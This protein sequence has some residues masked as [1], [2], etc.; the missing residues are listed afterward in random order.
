[1][2][3]RCFNGGQSV[4]FFQSVF[5]FF[6]SLFLCF[7]VS[8]RLLLNHLKYCESNV[9]LGPQSLLITKALFPFRLLSFSFSFFSFLFFYFSFLT[10]YLI[11]VFC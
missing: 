2:R 6:L 11:K 8:E 5:F 9:A 7:C 1:M 10:R 4:S 3:D